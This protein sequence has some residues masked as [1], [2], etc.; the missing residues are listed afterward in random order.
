MQRRLGQFVS[1]KPANQADRGPKLARQA[2][3]TRASATLPP[4][5]YSTLQ[6]IAKQK[7]V[8]VAWVTRAA[9]EKYIVDL[10]C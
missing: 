9:A 10:F 8:S 2:R 6:D 1:K 4:D 7:N 5:I 3:A